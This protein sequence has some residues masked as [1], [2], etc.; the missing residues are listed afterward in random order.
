MTSRPSRDGFW[1]WYKIKAGLEGMSSLYSTN[2]SFFASTPWAGGLTRPISI[3]QSHGLDASVGFD[4]LRLNIYRVSFGNGD[5][6]R[7]KRLIL[8]P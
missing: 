7:D 8:E 4:T 6:R 1:T 2:P 3:C 5:S